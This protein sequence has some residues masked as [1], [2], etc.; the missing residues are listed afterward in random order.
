[1][2]AARRRAQAMRPLRPRLPRR[3]LF[4][5]L[6]PALNGLPQAGGAKPVERAHDRSPR[7]ADRRRQLTYGRLGVSPHRLDQRLVVSLP[8]GESAIAATRLMIAP[9]P[10]C[11]VRLW[12]SLWLWLGRDRARKPVKQPAMRSRNQEQSR[13]RRSGT[14]AQ[15]D[16]DLVG[17]WRHQPPIYAGFFE[18]SNHKS[19]TVFLKY[20]G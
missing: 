5:Q 18:A 8:L 19:K 12:L 1:M 3:R 10:S 11:A 13:D 4:G 6:P 20:L 7:L 2:L 16:G 15:Q 9:T 17:Q 14:G